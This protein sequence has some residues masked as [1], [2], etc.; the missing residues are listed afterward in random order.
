MKGLFCAK[1]LKRSRSAKRRCDPVYRKR[2]LGT[3]YKQNI[4]GVAPQA[5]GIV[6]EKM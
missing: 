6:L 5:K 1:K 3:Q 2:L 4:I